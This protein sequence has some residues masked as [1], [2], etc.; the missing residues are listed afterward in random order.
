MY[1]GWNIVALGA[2]V[3]MIV[4]GATFNA[5]GLFVLPVSA[6]FGLS[7][8]NM[9]SGLILLNFGNAV[10]APLVGRL[11]DRIPARRIMAA[12]ALLFGLSFVTLGL[13][14]SLWLSAAVMA[15]PLAIAISAAGTITV[16]ALLARWFTARRGKAMMLA[17][18]GMSFGSIAVTPL[19]GWLVHA[20][21]WRTALVILGV[22][23][24]AVLLIVTAL[25]RERPGEEE[26]RIEQPAT[27]AGQRGASGAPMPVAAVLRMPQFWS[28]GISTA[29]VLGMAQA[30]SITLV[31]LAVGEGLTL[32][33]ATTLIS[34]SG[35]SAIA[36]K[37]LMSQVADRIDR[38]ILLALLFAL[39]ALI[40]GGFLVSRSFPALAACAAMVGVCSGTVAPIFYAL[41]ADRFGPTSFGTVR[42]LMTPVTALTGAVVVRFAGETYDRTGGY[43]LLFGTFAVTSLAAA[44]LMLATR[45]TQPYR[46]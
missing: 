15:V 46:G 33:Q 17:A 31:P 25:V 13:S 16:S 19:I 28:I 4:I 6:E 22:A 10:F 29:L 18:M 3:Y 24:G 36:A 2:V 20:Q 5:F 1:F 32:L 8:A 38:I 9:N 23:S 11:L 30:I 35:G 42:G 41:L 27:P 39:G 12:A 40:S 34:I 44:A 7:R 45:L 37:L 21:G 43:D 26:G 14:R